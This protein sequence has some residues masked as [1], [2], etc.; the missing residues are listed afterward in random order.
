MR[1]LLVA[2]VVLSL[3]PQQT[4]TPTPVRAGNGIVD[5]ALITS[6][7]PRYTT[8]AMLAKVQGTVELEAVVMPNGAVGDVR[9]TKSLDQ[10]LGLDQ[11][12]ITAA[13]KWKFKPGVDRS[14]TPVPVIVT[15]ILDFRIKDGQPDVPAALQ[16]V[17]A[18]VLLDVPQEFV[19]DARVLGS[20]GVVAPSV[21]VRVEPKYTS[22]AMLAKI[23]GTADVDVVIGTDGRVLRA[24]IARSLDA[25]HGLDDNALA[26]VKQWTFR[27]GTQAG[28]PVAVVARITLNFRLH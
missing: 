16:A 3:A 7:P 2:A 14:G 25:T 17:R 18:P 11:Q 1:A 5:P 19:Q 27:P 10:D 12:A 9:V 4:T 8:E 13:K 26:A 21:T 28:Q 6:V 23:Q 24:R 22:G 15:L 20:P